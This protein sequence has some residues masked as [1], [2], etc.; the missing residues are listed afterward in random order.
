MPDRTLANSK[1]ATQVV[2]ELCGHAEAVYRADHAKTTTGLFGDPLVALVRRVAKCWIDLA[3]VILA[4]ERSAVVGPVSLCRGPEHCHPTVTFR[5]KCQARALRRAHGGYRSAR[6]R[7][8]ALAPVVLLLDGSTV[9]L[10]RRTQ[11]RR[12]SPLSTTPSATPRQSCSSSLA[13]PA[14]S[15]LTEPVIAEAWQDAEALR[16]QASG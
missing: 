6:A 2:R 5:V 9:G 7:F 4:V 1:A 3:K 13:E 8:C 10:A 12:T 14:I 11:R 16:D 15:G